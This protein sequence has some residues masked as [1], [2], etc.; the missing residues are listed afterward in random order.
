MKK[1]IIVLIALVIASAAFAEEKRYT[2][3][4]DN[5]PAMGPDNAPV[6][7]VEFIDFQ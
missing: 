4:L 5:S 7:I 3:P 1:L 2:V 6:T